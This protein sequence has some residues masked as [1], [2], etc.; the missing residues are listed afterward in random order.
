MVPLLFAQKDL[1]FRSSD[2][3]DHV[4][5]FAGVQSVTIGELKD[6][7][8]EIWWLEKHESNGNS[9]HCFFQSSEDIAIY[10]V[11]LNLNLGPSMKQ[12]LGWKNM[13]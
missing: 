9:T 5:A 10:G 6:V 4:E 7:D 12:D 2:A 8:W 1:P 3:L 11:F 13:W